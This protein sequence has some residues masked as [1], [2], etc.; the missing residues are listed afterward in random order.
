[1]AKW[2][3]NCPI[4]RAIV[5][6]IFSQMIENIPEL[7]QSVE[8]QITPVENF[9]EAGNVETK[10]MRS[11]DLDNLNEKVASTVSQSVNGAIEKVEKNFL[12]NLSKLS[13]EISLLR[14]ELS[15]TV[16]N[17]NEAVKNLNELAL[18]LRVFMSDADNPFTLHGSNGNGWGKSNGNRRNQKVIEGV[19]REL[20]KYSET[21]D[22]S[23]LK[24]LLKDYV[25]SGILDSETGEALL[26]LID[27]IYK[28]KPKGFT[29]EDSIRFLHTIKGVGGNGR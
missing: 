20:W 3:C 21:Y 9:E 4:C 6:P 15:E 10:N 22:S 13:E 26:K 1:M 28:L 5:H 8:A 2:R 14:N 17:F 27:H 7:I 24:E 11:I 18:E 29:I 12:N 25:E 16:K 19:L 23:T